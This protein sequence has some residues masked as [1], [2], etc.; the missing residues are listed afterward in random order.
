MEKDSKKDL[1]VNGI[2]QIGLRVSAELHRDLVALA[3][4]DMRTLSNF[5]EV[6]LSNHVR[7][8]QK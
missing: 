6:I 3:E 5:C 4:E 1:P 8:K 2:K 7:Q